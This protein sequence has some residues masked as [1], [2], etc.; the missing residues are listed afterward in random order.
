LAA[1]EELTEG[2]LSSIGNRAAFRASTTKAL[3]DGLG[4]VLTK[5]KELALGFGSLFLAIGPIGWAVGAFTAL[6]VGVGLVYRNIRDT[7]RAADEM[8]KAIKESTDSLREQISTIVTVEDRTAALAKAYDNL[9]LAQERFNKY[10]EGD[11]LKKKALEGLEAA[12]RQVKEATNAPVAKGRYEQD[13]QMMGERT[14]YEQYERPI[15]DLNREAEGASPERQLEIAQKIQEIHRK[16]AMESKKWDATQTAFD[17]SALG[18][19]YNQLITSSGNIN[20]YATPQDELADLGKQ[21]LKLTEEAEARTKKFQELVASGKSM[22]EVPQELVNHSDL[23]AQRMEIT[24]KEAALKPYLSDEG[25][26]EYEVQKRLRIEAL[27]KRKKEIRELESDQAKAMGLPSFFGNEVEI[28]R[29]NEA[30]KTASPGRKQ[31]VADQILGLKADQRARNR[32]LEYYRGPAGAREED[33]DNA[34][35][36]SRKVEAAIAQGT[37]SIEIATLEA[38]KQGI[39]EDL[40]AA[41]ANVGVTKNIYNLT[42]EMYGIDKE[43]TREAQRQFELAQYK[44]NVL[45]AEKADREEVAN[46]KLKSLR[47]QNKV[48]E[49]LLKGDFKGAAKEMSEQEQRDREIELTDIRKA[50]FDQTGSAY[51]ADQAVERRKNEMIEENRAKVYADLISQGD[52]AAANTNDPYTKAGVEY[53]QNVRK[54]IQSGMSESDARASAEKTFVENGNGVLTPFDI[55]SA[56]SKAES[57]F[58]WL[59]K[60]VDTNNTDNRIRNL[61]SHVSATEMARRSKSTSVSDITRSI[62]EAKVLHNILKAVETENTIK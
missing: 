23:A 54:G 26:G 47:S 60:P 48:S 35:I 40:A 43:R 51:E 7:R 16:N 28:D 9:R 52:A 31:E 27:E 57:A 62:D 56:T 58:P 49:A 50:T 37:R 21:K 25:R 45:K 38:R 13:I 3:G 34:R 14:Y 4:F 1:G 32:N 59:T 8:S 36:R 39:N 10:S 6:A 41:E 15:E 30:S 29:L 61:N 33:D 53:L 20:S 22:S 42:K 17:N 18:K 12:E 55:T 2:A 24:R 11:S 5:V 46:R 19:E 44:A